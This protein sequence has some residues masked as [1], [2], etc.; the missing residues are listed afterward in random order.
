MNT[1]SSA[2]IERLLSVLQNE[3]WKVVRRRPEQLSL[4][5]EFRLRYPTLPD[6]F[7]YFLTTV[8]VCE[9]PKG[10]IWFL[11]EAE[12]NRKRDNPVAWD[13][14]EQ[15]TLEALREGGYT[16]EIEYV[17]DFWNAYVPILLADRGEY[18]YLAIGV[19][20]ENFGRIVKGIEP[21]FAESASQISTSF[22]DFCQR[23]T[24]VLEGKAPLEEFHDFV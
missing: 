16:D 24:E 1:E 3:G 6:D 22:T 18:I 13:H 7:L 14:Y 5:N 21:E 15:L 17:Q 10:V 11:T 2:V 8:E 12:Y 4:N 19:Q 20:P 9:A 23:Y